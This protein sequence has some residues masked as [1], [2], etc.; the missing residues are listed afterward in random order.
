MK[1]WKK[2]ILKA[3]DTMAQAIKTLNNESTG[4]VLV[5][6]ENGKLLGTVT[7]GDIRRALIA[8]SGINTL[9]SEFMCKDPVYSQM[10]TSKSSVIQIMNDL[11][12]LQLP[13]LDKSKNIVGLEA[14]QDLIK[15]NKFDNP[16][17]LMAG[18]VGA[19][20]KPLTDK[21]PKPLLNVGMKP[22]LEIIIDQLISYGFHNFFISI[23]YKAEMIRDYFGDGE[24][25]G[26]KI[27]YIHEKEPLGTGGALGLMPKNLPDL[28]II[29]MNGDILTKL[30]FNAM[31]DY[32]I[33]ND[34]LATIGTR[35]FDFQ[36]PYGVIEN[37]KN[38]I[39]KCISEKPVHKFFINAGIYI[40]SKDI[41]NLISGSHYL[42]MP[43]FL[44]S[45]IKLNKKVISFPIHEYWI[46]IGRISEFNKANL[47]VMSLFN[48]NQND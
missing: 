4:I 22:I 24:K 10:S 23:N 39:I 7:D 47:E 38:N 29:M 48:Y 14:L 9:L 27:Q 33:K 5:S 26:V 36:V 12:I 37:S 17:F 3:D 35:E 11:K 19:R 21:T 6:S 41:L 30:D 31:L 15:K 8:H 16:V 13:I 1:N 2:A 45:Q 18:G 28:P 46:D 40:L 34:G 32:H 42:D 20:L 44:D 25:W 43:Q